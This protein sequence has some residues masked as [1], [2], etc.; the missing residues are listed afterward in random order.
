MDAHYE[1]QGNASAIDAFS[2]INIGSIGFICAVL[3]LHAVLYT[4]ASSFVA[5][6]LPLDAV[7]S[8]YWG[9]EWQAGYFK[10][11][12]MSAWMIEAV[13]QL[14]GRSDWIIFATAET[15]TILAILPVVL[16]VRQRY[17]AQAGGYTVLAAFLTH[18]TTLSAVEYNVN[19][20]FLPFWGWMVF[21][22]LKAEETDKLSWWVL[23]GLVSAGGMLGKYTAAIFLMSSALWVVFARRDLLARTGPYIAALVF[24]AAMLPHVLWLAQI[25]FMP[26][27]YAFGRTGNSASPWYA[28]IMMPLKYLGEFAY[29]VLPMALALGIAAG[30]AKIRSLN[31]GSVASAVRRVG[32]ESFLFAAIGPI[33]VITGLSLTLGANIKTVWS[34]PLGVVFA[35]P[36]GVAAASL[37]KQNFQKR[38]LATWVVFYGLLLTIFVAMMVIAPFVKKYPKRMLHDGPALARLVE[39]HWG[40]HE[41]QPFKYLVG[42]HWPGGSVAWYTPSRPTF[43]ERANLTYSPWIDLEDLQSKGAVYVD[44]KKPAT[45]VSGMCVVDPQKVLWP[46]PGGR[47][48]K[49]HPEVWMA[50][51]K[52]ATGPDAVTCAGE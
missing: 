32:S 30:W 46:A 36:I 10:H 3:V 51:L 41:S 26:I 2:K 24:I 47:I 45:K 9:K 28:H 16:I 8:L 39:Q 23:F 25:D 15:C 18:F 27:E 14:L 48:Y 42:D 17:G 33:L 38:F 21:T 37:E 35:G 49:K 34:M 44:Y 6:N 5:S 20:G 22:F 29:S 4:L 19:M 7:E 11:P 12:P 50:V 52:P 31:W 40:K 1:K 13:V 43:F